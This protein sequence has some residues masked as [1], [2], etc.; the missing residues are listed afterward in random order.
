[1]ILFTFIDR[2]FSLLFR[3]LVNVRRLVDPLHIDK[4]LQDWIG[5]KL[6]LCSA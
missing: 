1:M 6:E 3:E 5:I 4:R 2:G